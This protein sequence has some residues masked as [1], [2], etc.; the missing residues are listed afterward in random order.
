M[1]IINLE[2][3][4]D[5]PQATRDSRKTK[6]LLIELEA[7]YSLLLRAEDL[8]NPLAI[9]N[10][11][12]LKELKQKQRLREI[13]AAP[14]PEQKQEVLKLLQQ[15][16]MAVVENQQDL[17]NKIL[18]ALLQDEKLSSFV[19]IRK[20]KMLLLRLLPHLSI[21]IY[22]LQLL[23]IWIKLLHSISLVG[24]RDTMGDNVLPRFHPLFKR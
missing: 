17:L 8:K 2:K 12:K 7:L 20:G 21:D 14:T 15:E 22:S 18:H 11:E 19:G 13:E 24:R 16:S 9:S 10:A 6:Q 3:D 1:D 5:S 4:S 23:E